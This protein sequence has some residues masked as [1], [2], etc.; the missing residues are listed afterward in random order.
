MARFGNA[1]L[2]YAGWCEKR[3]LPNLAMSRLSPAINIS[4]RNS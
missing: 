3:L 1:D 4:T 2:Q